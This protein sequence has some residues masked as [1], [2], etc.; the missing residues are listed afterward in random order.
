MEKV[1]QKFVLHL[2]FSKNT[3]TN[4]QPPGEHFSN[5]VTLQKTVFFFFV[6]HAASELSSTKHVLQ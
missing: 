4:T 3:E 5:L 2:T 1:S 6:T